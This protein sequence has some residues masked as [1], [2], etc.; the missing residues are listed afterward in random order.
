MQPCSDCIDGS[1]SVR[2]EKRPD[3]VEVLENDPVYPHEESPAQ[4]LYRSRLQVPSIVRS[5]M[6]PLS[7][8]KVHTSALS[9]HG[10]A[11]QHVLA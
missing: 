11:L 6:C 8:S 1:S 3:V 2:L 4:G 9:L 5:G 7:M 10:R